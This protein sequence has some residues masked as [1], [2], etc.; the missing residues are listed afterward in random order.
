MSDLYCV[1]LLV[2]VDVENKNSG[3]EVEIFSSI[4]FFEKVTTFSLFGNVHFIHKDT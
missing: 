3:N 2:A 1:V 4:D